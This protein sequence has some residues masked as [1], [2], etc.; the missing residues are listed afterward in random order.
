VARPTKQGID[1]F[2]IDCQFDKKTRMYL[3]ETGAVG[4]AVLVTLWQMIYTEDGY[5]IDDN[6]DLHLLVKDEINVDVNEVSDCINASLR[7]NIFDKSLHEKYRILT[8]SGIQKRYFDAAKKKKE[9]SFTKEFALISVDSYANLID[10]GI[11]PV[12]VAGNATKEKEKEKEDIAGVKTPSESSPRSEPCPY[13][14]IIDL[15]HT[16]LPMLPQVAKLTDAR[17]RAISARWKNGMYGM[18][19]WEAY[20]DDVAQS[21]FLTGKVDPS[22]GRKQFVADIDFL[23]RESTIVKMQE[24]KYNG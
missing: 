4:L 3:I 9:V 24:G 15:Y 17:K 2:S 8:S 12:S 7:R 23:I 10:S 18:E 19:N 13:Q 5:F 20:F 16:K 6:D 14:K 22:P 1:Y 21:R 11:N